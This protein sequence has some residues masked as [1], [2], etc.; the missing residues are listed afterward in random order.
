MKVFEKIILFKKYIAIL[1]A[2][3]YYRVID[4]LSGKQIKKQNFLK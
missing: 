4:S 2:Y 3:I 1:N